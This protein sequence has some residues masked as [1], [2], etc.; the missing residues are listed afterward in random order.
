MMPKCKR[1]EASL[2]TVAADD[3]ELSERTIECRRMQGRVHFS[4]ASRSAESSLPTRK[5][6]NA[7]QI[8]PPHSIHRVTEALERL[9]EEDAAART[10]PTS[11][12]GVQLS[13]VK[14]PCILT[15]RIA[16]E[17]AETP[18][19]IEEPGPRQAAT[20]LADGERG[21]E[22]AVGH[23]GSRLSRSLPMTAV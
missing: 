21:D 7:L 4:K 17:P 22:R 1:Q 13:G 10:A 11:E 15:I 8:L 19:A 18:G 9:M 2:V 20:R 6:A 16:R 14:R 23:R 5:L 3:T 12:D